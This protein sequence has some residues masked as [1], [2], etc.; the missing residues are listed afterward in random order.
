MDSPLCPVCGIYPKS[1]S[2]ISWLCKSPQDVWSGNFKKLQRMA[3]MESSL[4]KLVGLL[5]TIL[6]E[7]EMASF[8]VIA[9]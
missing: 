9:Y 1:V 8:A 4:K 2:R 7:H 6:N 5:F 3:M